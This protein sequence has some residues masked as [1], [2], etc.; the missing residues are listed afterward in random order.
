[1]NTVRWAEKTIAAAGNKNKETNMSYRRI[2][3]NSEDGN[4]PL[5]GSQ[6]EKR[7]NSRLNGWYCSNKN[8]KYSFDNTL[9]ILNK[10]DSAKGGTGSI[11]KVSKVLF[12]IGF[13]IAVISFITGIADGNLD[14]GI[15][16][17]IFAL[18]LCL[19]SWKL[20]SFFGGYG[21]LSILDFIV[22]MIRGR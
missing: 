22:R 5:C 2:F 8:C 14:G 3:E 18:L 17:I 20:Y 4:C 7:N 9:A 11:Y 6:A 10:A 19:I 21:R 15:G 1:L 12:I 16:G 13:I